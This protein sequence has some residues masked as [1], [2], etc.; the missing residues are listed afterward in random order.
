MDNKLEDLLKNSWLA[1]VLAIVG[2]LILGALGNGVWESLLKPI[3][4]WFRDIVLTIST[5]GLQSLRDG[6]YYDIGKENYERASVFIMLMMTGLIFGI[7]FGVITKKNRRS[8]GES[9]R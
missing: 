9:S 5:L 6:M 3:I 1:R 2:A 7:L 4:L 8:V